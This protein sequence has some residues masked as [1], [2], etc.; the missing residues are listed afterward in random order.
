M[1]LVR[2]HN[3]DRAWTGVVEKTPRDVPIGQPLF[4]IVEA[5]GDVVELAVTTAKG[6]IT[7]ITGMSKEGDTLI[8][9]GLHIDGPGTGSVGLPELRGLAIELGRQQG[10]RR[11]T[12]HGGTRTTGANTGKIP[13]PMTFLV[14]DR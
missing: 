13:R 10:A 6:D 1:L 4:R 12:I 3:D 11:V 5:D 8:L 2:A 7:I 14:G 9:S